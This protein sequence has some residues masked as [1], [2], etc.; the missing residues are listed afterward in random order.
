MDNYLQN[1][2]TLSYYWVKMNTLDPN[3]LDEEGFLKVQVDIGNQL[4]SLFP[5]LEGENDII[6]PSDLGEIITINEDNTLGSTLQFYNLEEG[7]YYCIVV[8]ELNNH[9]VANVTPFYYIH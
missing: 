9:R 8:N 6:L 1:S 7:Y 3:D 2:D 5:D 4:N